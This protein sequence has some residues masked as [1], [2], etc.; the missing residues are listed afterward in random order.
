[1]AFL[2]GTLVQTVK[3]VTSVDRK[4]LA[5]EKA[6]KGNPSEK[7]FALRTIPGGRLDG[8]RPSTDFG[9]YRPAA[10]TAAL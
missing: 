2:E 4:L 1:M 6:W 7:D 9:L 5:I 8:A 3:M 10:A